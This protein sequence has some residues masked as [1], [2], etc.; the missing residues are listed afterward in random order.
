MSFFKRSNK[1]K[2]ASAASSPAQTPRASMQSSR[3]SDVKLTHE[4]AIYK[5]AHNKLTFA[6]AGINQFQAYSSNPQSSLTTTQET[7]KPT[8][9]L[10]KR[11]NKNKTASA[12]STPAQTPRT[13]MQTIRDTTGTK[14]TPEE[15]LYKI[16]HN[17]MSN[18]ST[19]PFIR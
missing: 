13:S 2:S 17:M 19:G 10:F 6:A 8:M 1:N 3:S 4:Q 15:A 14:M 7:L 16:S 18:A 9:S 5:I 12:A 11:S